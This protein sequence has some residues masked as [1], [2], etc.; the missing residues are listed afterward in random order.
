M[1][2]NPFLG[3]KF[4]CSGENYVK[5]L[6]G[7]EWQKLPPIS[8]EIDPSNLCSENC[9][10]CMFS[11]YRRKKPVSISLKDITRIIRQLA[12][13]GC[14]GLTF[15][16][17]GDPLS[18][19]EVF[20]KAFYEAINSGM[21]CALVTNGVLIDKYIDSISDTCTYVRVSVD[22][23]NR[24]TYRRL[25]GRDL[26]NKVWENLKKLRE[27]FKGDLG[28]AF[29]VHPE[30]Y[31]EVKEFCNLARLHDLSYAGIRPVLLSG[32]SLSEKIV[33]SVVQQINSFKSDYDF[34]V[35]TRMARFREVIEKDRGFTDCLA[36]PL[37]SVIGA[38][39]NVYLCCAYRGNEKFS[40]GNL[41]D[42][43]F[44][45]IWYGEKRKKIVEGINIDKCI[46]CRLAQ[47]NIMLGDLKNI[48]HTE[49]L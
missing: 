7:D 12:K 32:Y 45:E 23:G 5:G 9:V 26:W 41:K 22:A 42:S 40:F 30:N 2:G 28:V 35:F 27:R 21:K 24:E 49:F 11:E 1:K 3:V 20:P 25:H 4:L 47:Y 44:E 6:L 18:N 15:T 37:L 36:T 13:I 46:P 38:D 10:W 14:K 17:G 31:Q 29:L 48:A 39:L 33:N 34:P 19:P 16:G 43:S 8:A